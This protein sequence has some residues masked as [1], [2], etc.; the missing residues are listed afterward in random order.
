MSRESGGYAPRSGRLVFVFLLTVLFFD[1]ADQ[2]LFSPFLNDLLRDFFGGTT[3]VVP[4]GWVTFT[5][6]IL[7]ALSMLAAGFSADRISRLKICF[8]GAL[9]YGLSSTLT[10]LAPHGEPG[11]FFFFF[12]RALNGLGVGVVVPA[13]F[14]LAGD[15]IAPSRRATAFGFMSVAMLVGRLAGFT[16]A[17][18]FGP[19][20][21]SAYAFLG[22]VNLV[23]AA[24]L[25]VSKE[26]RRGS[27]EDEL[28]E[29]IL[30]GAE[31][32]FRISPKDIKLIGAARS[33][34]WLVLN[35]IDVI[36]GSMILF[37]IFK[38]MKERHNMDA[39]AV[40]FAIFLAF[41]AG[42][43][44]A[45]VFGR[46]GDW[47]FRR[48]PRAKVLVALFCNAFPIV[49]MAF[50]VAAKAW[51]PPQAGLWASL[52]VPGIWPIVF[53]VAAAMFIN[54]GVNPN[55]YSSLTDI[56]LPEHRAAMISLAS[57]ADMIGNALGPLFASYISTLWGIQAAMW[58]VLVFWAANIVLWVPVLKN[59][60]GDLETKYELLR[61][62]A[63]QM[64]KGFVPGRA[65][66]G[67]I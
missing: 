14:S 16:I 15:L 64:K 43:L 40:N 23:V 56:N 25:I 67:K 54:Q 37:L 31:Y 55:W 24:S 19:A 20:W 28:R 30:E 46:I 4:L 53:A 36:P 9:L 49:F 44:G 22:A 10:A 52:A 27:Q 17:G 38:Y 66:S 58:S 29:A 63:E 2:S 3:N 59:I 34:I 57:V 61:G 47:G 1:F 26:P 6:T 35:F 7:S 51:V 8:A 18:A 39:P 12:T 11:Y 21:R 50:F 42:A 13:V 60:R 32:R 65:P 41:L 5:M 48:D 33:N 62:R 45:V